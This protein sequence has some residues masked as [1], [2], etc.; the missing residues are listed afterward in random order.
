MFPVQEC[1]LFRERVP[2]EFM[3]QQIYQL[4]PSSGLYPNSSHPDCLAIQS[5]GALCG[6][7]IP[8]NACTICSGEHAPIAYLERPLELFQELFGGI[9]LNC[10]LLLLDAFLRNMYR[11]SRVS[12]GLLLR[13]LRRFES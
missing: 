1:V 13:V 12:R 8:G 3:C 2:G 9:I 11:S 5:V 4:L 7:P 6:C 10:E